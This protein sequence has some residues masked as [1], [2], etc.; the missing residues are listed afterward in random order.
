MTEITRRLMRSGWKTVARKD[1]LTVVAGGA[2]SL[3]DLTDVSGDTGP[4]KAPIGDDAGSMFTLTQV[5]TQQDLEAI[6]ASVAAVDWHT[7]GV[8]GEPGFAPEWYNAPGAWAPCRY[9]RTLNSSVFVEGVV[10][11]NGPLNGEDAPVTIFQLP[12]DCLPGG[13]LMFTTVSGSAPI[14]PTISTVNVLADGRV[15]WGGY[16]TVGEG[17]EGFVSLCGIVFS[18]QAAS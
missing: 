12:A 13:D 8:D 1:E 14:G 5:V 10:A 17:A 11:H 15:V 9:R 2:Q 16:V 3:T 6:L 18:V 7:V 4:N